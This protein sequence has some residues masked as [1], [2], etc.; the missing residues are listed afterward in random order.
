MRKFVF[1]LAV[2]SVWVTQ[3]VCG[4]GVEMPALSDDSLTVD[5]NEVVVTATRTPLP[6]KNTPVITR[7]ITSR[8]I[9][10]SGAVTLQQALERELAGVEFHQAGYG[11]SLSFQGLD[12]RYVLF[13][14]DGE[15]IAGE[16]YGNI[17][18]S[19]IPLSIVSRIEVVRGASSV[20]YGS[21][22][23][24]AVVNVI[25]KSPA[26]NTRS[27]LRCDT[28]RPTSATAAIRWREMRRRETRASIATSSICRT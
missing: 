3:G 18:Y 4:S 25:T 1:C 20:L 8:D 7:V 19:R 22:A 15:R 23:M 12:S 11:S 16:T 9:E 28:A 14:L 13:L 5:M 2:C 10:R 27:R 6:L 17:D 21:N 24:G 26:I